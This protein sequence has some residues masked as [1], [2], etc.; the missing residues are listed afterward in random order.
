[1]VEPL[2]QDNC[3]HYKKACERGKAQ[4]NDGFETRSAVL[5]E[6]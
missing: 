3:F 2:C 1:M 5:V 4:A 6:P